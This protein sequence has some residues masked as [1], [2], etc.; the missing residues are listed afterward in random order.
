MDPSDEGAATIPLQWVVKER[1]RVPYE[2]RQLQD[3]V[4]VDGTVCA[5]WTERVEIQDGADPEYDRFTPGLYH[6]PMN[7]TTLSYAL[8]VPRDYRRDAKYPFVLYWHG[9]GEKGDNNLKS[10][11][12]TLNAVTW[13]T[14]EEQAKHPCFVLVP[15]C[16]TEG[17]WIDPDTYETT[18]VFDAVC[19]LV[20]SLFDTYSIDL[21]RV[22]CT[23]FSMGGMAAWETAKRYHKLVAGTLIYA[24]QSNYEDLEVLKGSA[25]WVFHGE[26][27]DKAMAG[28]VDNME[29]LEDAGAV[30]S[31]AVWDGS[32]RG[33]AA[34]RAAQDQLAGGAH[35]LHTLYREGSIPG[36][37]PHEHGW[38]PAITNEGVRD[39]LFSLVNPDPSSEIHTYVM[40][41]EHTPLRVDLGFDGAEVAQISGGSRHNLALLRDGGVLAWGFNVNGQ[42]GDGRSGAFSS[43][44]TPVRVDGLRDIVQVAAGNN[45][46][47]ALT[48]DGTVYGWGS[49]NCGQL[50]D[51]DTTVRRT[52]PVRIE[53]IADAAA[54]A[55]GDSYAVALKRDGTVWAWGT[56][57]NGQ[58]GNGTYQSS[59]RPVQAVDPEDPT[60]FLSDVVR[61]EAGVRTVTALKKDGTIRCWGDGE[62][63]QT[64]TGVASHGPGT[65]VP[66]APLDT[67]DPTGRVTGVLRVAQGRCFTAVLKNDGTVHSW[68]LHRH[69]EL[70]L[71][72]YL[73]EVDPSDPNVTPDF[74]AAV[75][76][77]RRVAGLNGV[78]QIAAGMNHT[79]ALKDDGSV[80]TWG[81]NKLMGSGVLGVGEV[82]QS[83]LPVRVEALTHI[84][85]IFVGL[86]HNFAIG[87]DG[88]VW[89]WG[90]ARN[91]RLGPPR[92]R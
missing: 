6:D 20:F 83:A 42:L 72:D 55:A 54:I 45:F 23:G 30:I 57:M 52:F 87:W 68:G 76:H 79:V 80:W 43:R 3:V 73:P 16:P 90:N 74:F 66:F 26:D 56:N 34:V 86:N 67:F 39:W 10:L 1:R 37:R 11:L 49:N 78:R 28:N 18:D 32:L 64:G 81:Y 15:Q 9:G 47:L 22:Y 41:A 27:D 75:V 61:V 31:R 71:G 17:D 65:T 4:Y 29:T 21:T 13:V 40:P 60:G 19:R 5:P 35:I 63:G 38:R 50:G 77:P 85:E 36:G 62:Y 59:R 82:E 33:P 88:T 24:G 8:F 53:G 14:D 25:L 92:R 84:R 2:V 58:L 12:C 44:E 46:S 91:G 89:A 70:G 48:A 51:T 69:G 7:G